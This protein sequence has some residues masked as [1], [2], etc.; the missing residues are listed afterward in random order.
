MSTVAEIAQECHYIFLML[1]FPKDVED[2]VLTDMNGCK[3]QKGAYLIDHT[4]SS[5]DLTIRIGQMAAQN[6]VHFIDAPVSGGDIGARNGTLVTMVGGA[7]GKLKMLS[8]SCL[9]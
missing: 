8:I 5:P 4:T 3:L 1:G 2:V 7:A 9:Y 6:G